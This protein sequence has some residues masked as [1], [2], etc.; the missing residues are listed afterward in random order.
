[1]APHTPRASGTFGRLYQILHSAL[2]LLYMLISDQGL[3][4]CSYILQSHT[5]LL[6]TAFSLFKFPEVG[7]HSPCSL[8]IFC[9]LNL[10]AIVVARLTELAGTIYKNTVISPPQACR[11]G[12]QARSL[13]F[14]KG[15]LCIRS[16]FRHGLGIS[17]LPEG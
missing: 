3:L 9:I 7:K 13:K 11:R 10:E 1:M 2:V 4:C 17:A 16:S 8:R 15:C 5:V 14:K 6:L 12:C